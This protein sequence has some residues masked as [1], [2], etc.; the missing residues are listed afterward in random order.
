MLP[1]WLILAIT[2]PVVVVIALLGCLQCLKGKPAF[3]HFHNNEEYT[4]EARSNPGYSADVDSSEHSTSNSTEIQIDPLP[5]ILT[6]ASSRKPRIGCVEKSKQDATLKLIATNRPFPRRQLTYLK[7][8]GSGWF[9]QI[10]ESDA[11]HITSGIAR[12]RVVVKM[13]KDDASK[14]EQ[15]IFHEDVAPFRELDHINVLRLLGQCTETNPILVILEHAQMGDLKTY[16]KKQ[17]LDQSNLQHPRLLKFA[18]DAASGLACLHRHGY[19]HH[20]FAARSCLVFADLTVKVGDFGITEELFPEDYYSSRKELLPVRWMAP[21]SLSHQADGWQ[22]AVITKEANIWSFGVLL[23]EVLTFA[24]QPYTDLTDELVLQLV[25][26][27]KVIKLNKP[28]LEIAF[29]NRLY[30]VMQFCWLNPGQ[31]PTVTEAHALLEHLF[32]KLATPQSV[33]SVFE[34]KWNSIIPSEARVVTVT[35][36]RAKSRQTR[37]DSFDTDFVLAKDNVI[38]SVESTDVPQGKK[39]DFR[40]LLQDVSRISAPESQDVDIET[41]SVSVVNGQHVA[42]DMPLSDFDQIALPSK[43][44]LP[45]HLT[46]TPVEKPPPRKS[47]QPKIPHNDASGLNKVKSLNFDASE[48]S[49][50]T[51]SKRKS[52]DP[53]SETGTTENTQ[54]HTATSLVDISSSTQ[55]ADSDFGEMVGVENMTD[56]FPQ[57]ESTLLIDDRVVSH[58]NT[59]AKSEDFRADTSIEDS[60]VSVPNTLNITNADSSPESEQSTPEILVPA[61]ETSVVSKESTISEHLS[62]FESNS[63]IKSVDEVDDKI[64]SAEDT[65]KSEPTAKDIPSALEHNDAFGDFVFEPPIDNK[66]NMTSEEQLP[67][68]VSNGGGQDA[69]VT[70][71]NVLVLS[72]TPEPSLIDSRAENVNS[73]VSMSDELKV[74]SLTDSDPMASMEGSEDEPMVKGAVLSPDVKVGTCVD[75]VSEDEDEEESRSPSLSDSEDDSSSSS[76]SSSDSGKSYICDNEDHLSS[77]LVNGD[78]CV[79]SDTSCHEDA[80][81]DDDDNDYDDDDDDDFH[82]DKPDDGDLELVSEMYLSKGVV[83][84]QAFERSLLPLET[85]PEDVQTVSDTSSMETKFDDVFSAQ[86]NF[87]WD[88]FMG[89]ELVGKDRLCDSSPKASLDMSDWRLDSSSLHSNSSLRK[90]S[91]D[92]RGYMGS[93]P[94]SSSTVDSMQSSLSDMEV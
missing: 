76:S 66:A 65:V 56:S 89:E 87:E 43:T 79:S 30:E 26:E 57:Q 31:R 44:L 75:Y 23:W 7:E 85:I 80:D 73:S 51:D 61:D 39:P 38:V 63:E 62:G 36:G 72:A 2:V 6:Q 60:F 21:E 70:E 1:I 46:S 77:E 68:V 90:L 82:E 28:D 5:D 92:R 41:L 15:K 58:Q 11:E 55:Y 67:P 12:S 94:G 88:D 59:S 40:S 13:M 29:I 52:P 45:E 42:V 24:S 93:D 4:T 64:L 91:E 74:D 22:T 27:D 33:D 34:D 86:D 17:K 53:E 71:R 78:V 20:D 83:S 25:V 50:M 49:L 69:S 8:I 19:I 14:S 84:P 81:R 35:D 18:I 9:G 10:I 48:S 47:Q 37:T 54:Y 32:T 3:K 16:L